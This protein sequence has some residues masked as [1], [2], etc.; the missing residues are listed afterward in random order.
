MP[1]ISVGDSSSYHVGGSMDGVDDVFASA[2]K[3][4]FDT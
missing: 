2:H 3:S 1:V 4:L